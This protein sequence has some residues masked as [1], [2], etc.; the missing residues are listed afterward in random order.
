LLLYTAYATVKETIRRL[1]MRTITIL[2][3]DT[4]FLATD[5]TT[6]TRIEKNDLYAY[7]ITMKEKGYKVICTNRS[8]H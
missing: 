8:T 5:G 6:N 2:N 3:R 7:L 1:T 4:F